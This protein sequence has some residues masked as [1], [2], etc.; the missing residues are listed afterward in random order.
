MEWVKTDWSIYVIIAALAL[1]TYATRL[2]GVW[3]LRYYALPRPVEQFMIYFPR[4]L[5]VAIIAPPL[6]FGSMAER[7][8]GLVT[9]ITTLVTRSILFPLVAGLFTLIFM[10]YLLS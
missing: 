10:R 3:I 4:C 7:I 5:L 1:T 6:L 8:A 9:L 2:A